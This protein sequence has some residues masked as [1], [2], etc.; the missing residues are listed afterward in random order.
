MLV[1]Y[2]IVLPFLLFPPS[3]I[4]SPLS[5]FLSLL[6]FFLSLLSFFL[7]LSPLTLSLSPL[8]LSFSLPSLSFSL[9]C[10]L[11]ASRF[12][13]RVVSH[14]TPPPPP[15]PLY[16]W[17]NL[18]AS[19]LPRVC[20][21]ERCLSLYFWLLWWVPCSC[22]CVSVWRWDSEPLT[23]ASQ[24]WDYK[25]VHLEFLH[26]FNSHHKVSEFMRFCISVT[27]QRI[28]SEKRVYS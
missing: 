10:H 1:C 19:K 23:L 15:V 12:T 9:P 27:C 2:N 4:L 25:P 8:T 16:L 14:T 11:L 20:E 21:R 28:V 3:C 22:V 5:F 24:D 6:S 17:R 13:N 7:S 26:W 18:L